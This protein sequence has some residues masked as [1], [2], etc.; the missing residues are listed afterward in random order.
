MNR[1]LYLIL[2]ALITV[3]CSKSDDNDNNNQYIPNVT[4]DTGNLVNTNLPQYSQLK[5][6]NN[7]VVLNNN[8]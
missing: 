5:Y 8:Y 2:L 3:S 7:H 1:I 6:A 4:F